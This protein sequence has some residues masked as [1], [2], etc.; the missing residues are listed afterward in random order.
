MDQTSYSNKEVIKLI[1]DRF[2]P[3]RV[4]RDQRPDIDKRYNMG[5]WPSTAFL[6]PDGE[7]L[8]GGTYIPPQQMVALL[9]R[10]GELYQ[11]N[12]GTIKSRIK[13]LEDLLPCRRLEKDKK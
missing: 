12:K 8:T 5:G 3:I 4:D 2:V 13:D 9:E 10:V 6:T 11:K 1:E 7:V